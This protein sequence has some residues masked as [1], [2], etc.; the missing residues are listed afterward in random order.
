M[1][2]RP[3]WMQKLN[4]AWEKRSII[5]LSGVAARG[6]DNTCTDDSGCRLREL[7]SAVRAA[8]AG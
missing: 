4:E 8:V 7:R 5:W 1:I 6:Q 2:C 3:L